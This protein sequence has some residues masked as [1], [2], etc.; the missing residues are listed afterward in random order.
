MRIQNSYAAAVAAAV[1]AVVFSAAFQ[2]VQ[3][4]PILIDN[5][6]TESGSATTGP[7]TSPSVTASLSETGSFGGFDQLNQGVNAPQFV[8][9]GS[10]TA[11][12][13][14]T[15]GVG[16]LSVANNGAGNGVS[17]GVN[18][19]FLWSKSAGS[20][21][22]TAGGNNALRIETGSTVLTGT[23]FRPFITVNDGNVT[24]FTLYPNLAANTASEIPFA[25]FTGVDFSQTVS[26]EVGFETPDPIP[27]STSFSQGLT[28]TNVS[29]VP[30]P[31]Q[32][33]L[34]AGVGAALGMWRLRKLRR[35]GEAAGDAIAS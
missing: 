25:D 5:F 2:P 8:T 11:T 35:N 3:A 12:T 6:T 26:I 30:E 21:D 28:L 19:A 27:G 31:T 15:A 4:A 16:T 32:L 14:R 24:G 18:G 34:V 9:R 33:V 22:L 29:V 13:S 20:V 17:S 7:S 10:R 23:V 1:A